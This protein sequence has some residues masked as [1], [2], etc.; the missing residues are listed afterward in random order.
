VVIYPDYWETY[1]NSSVTLIS[2]GLADLDADDDSYMVTECDTANQQFSMEFQWYTSYT[3]ADIT[4]ITVERQAHCSRS[5]TPRFWSYIKEGD[6][7]SYTT[8]Q[9]FTTWPTTDEWHTWDATS[10]ATYLAS[11]GTLTVMICGCPENSN[12]Y[13]AS[14]DVLR[15]RLELAE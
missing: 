12:N 13:Q 8:I 6:N 9:D 4:R 10:V 14:L 1:S 3:P 2:G 5:D 11:D 15:I 7:S